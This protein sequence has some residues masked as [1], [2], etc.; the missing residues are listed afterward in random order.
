M[1]AKLAGF[2]VALSVASAAASPAN[3]HGTRVIPA[4]S[5]YLVE[6]VEMP[7]RDGITLTGTGYQALI[8]ARVRLLTQAGQFTDQSPVA[9][10]LNGRTLQMVPPRSPT[11]SAVFETW[12]EQLPSDYM[13]SITAGFSS[14][15][16]EPNKITAHRYVRDNFRHVYASYAVTVELLADTGKYRVT[17]AASPIPADVRL[18]A[19]EGWKTALPSHFLV[20]QILGDG[21]TMALQLYTDPN[22]GQTLV[23][24]L[25]VGK[26]SAITLRKEAA[27][28][29]YADDAQFVLAAPR[30]KANGAAREPGLLPETLSGPILWVYV[31]GYGRY[32][33]SFL[34]H[35]EQGFERAGEVSANA[36]NFAVEGN[37]FRIECA[38]RISGVGSGAYNVY[39]LHDPRWEPAD[40][41]DRARFMLGSAPGVE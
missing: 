38:G 17:Y 22:N 36:L 25:H 33:L 9:V 23:E 4:Q 37:L 40:P 13:E 8:D 18:P 24:Y 11:P 29:S 6:P 14:V 16:R 28:D 41:A 39:A 1:L 30:L 10:T 12:V 34:P 7:A 5:T 21:E 31:P 20:P 19:S 3:Q 26:S 2:F 27:H 35:Q 15:D 32:V